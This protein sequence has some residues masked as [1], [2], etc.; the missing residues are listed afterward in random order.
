LS[1]LNRFSKFLDCWK[2]YKICYKWLT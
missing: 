2:A 1:N